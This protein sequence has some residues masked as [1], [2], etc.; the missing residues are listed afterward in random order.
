MWMFNCC[1]WLEKHPI[2]RGFTQLLHLGFTTR[3]CRTQSLGCL[4]REAA[5]QM[6]RLHRGVR[7]NGSFFSGFPQIF[8]HL[9]MRC[10]E[11][12]CLNLNNFCW[13]LDVF[14]HSLRG[15]RKYWMVLKFRRV[16]DGWFGFGFRG[17]CIWKFR[18]MGFESFNA[19]KGFGP[20]QEARQP[21]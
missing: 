17:F 10:Y 14:L 15:L 7:E 1:K 4:Q 2:H 8:K 9:V 3:R 6:Q 12:F 11:D 18:G 20:L 13:C 16:P 5:L 19:L 21:F